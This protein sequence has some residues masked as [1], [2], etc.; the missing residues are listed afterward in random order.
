MNWRS[1]GRKWREISCLQSPAKRNALKTK[2]ES[3]MATS[4]GTSHAL[5]AGMGMACA[6]L[7]EQEVAVA[8]R[9]AHHGVGVHHGGAHSVQCSLLPHGGVDRAQ[10]VAAGCARWR[11]SE[12][13]GLPDRHGRLQHGSWGLRQECWLCQQPPPSDT[14]HRSCALSTSWSTAW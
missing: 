2:S 8:S 12:M 10:P 3:L 13:C 5:G 9:E 11:S 6:L 14:E 4:A 1:C 7:A